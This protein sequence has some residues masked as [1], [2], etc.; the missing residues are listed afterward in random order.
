MIFLNKLLIFFSLI[1]LI[2]SCKYYDIQYKSVSN[3]KI[4]KVDKKNVLLS[5]DVV[6]FNPNKYNLK[7]KQ[8]FLDFYLNDQHFA[9]LKLDNMVKIKKKT[10]SIVYLPINVNLSDGFLQKFLILA[11]SK[12][13]NLR[14][15]GYLKGSIFILSK[16]QKIDETI[17]LSPDIFKK[18]KDDLLK[19]N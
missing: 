4:N 18:F 17:E 19:I 14:I 11:V 5:A 9:V 8:S 7:I 1:F 16:K 12:N 2:S 13:I 6:L 3:F 15:A 10:E